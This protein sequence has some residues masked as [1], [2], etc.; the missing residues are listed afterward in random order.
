M[1]IQS[2]MEDFQRE[3]PHGYNNWLRLAI[4]NAQVK[5]GF[6][7]SPN[8]RYASER[9]GDMRTGRGGAGVTS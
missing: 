1:N 8:V 2:R 3:A 6:R 4:I 9:M 5:V 7:S